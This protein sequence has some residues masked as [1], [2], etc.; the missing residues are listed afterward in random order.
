MNGEIYGNTHLFPLHN[1]PNPM[2]VGWKLW[3]ELAFKWPETSLFRSTFF[4]TC[5]IEKLIIT[6][7]EPI[8]GV[9]V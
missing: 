7:Q 1:E 6:H 8:E 5:I 3:D 2:P 9:Q 4:I